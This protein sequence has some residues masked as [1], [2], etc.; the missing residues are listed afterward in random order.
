VRIFSYH[1]DPVALACP[2]ASGRPR[3][4]CGY[5]AMASPSPA[6]LPPLAKLIASTGFRDLECPRMDASGFPEFSAGPT[7]LVRGY[8]HFLALLGWCGMSAAQQIDELCASPAG[9][10]PGHRG[11]EAYERVRAGG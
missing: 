6:G 4:S 9:M 10:G 1:F 8:D 3:L 2:P 11:R 7:P 5:R